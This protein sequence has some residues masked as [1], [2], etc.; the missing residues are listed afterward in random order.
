[1]IQIELSFH[2]HKR[3]KHI[4]LD[5]FVSCVFIIPKRRIATLDYDISNNGQWMVF[6]LYRYPMALLFVLNGQPIYVTCNICRKNVALLT[7]IHMESK[8]HI[9]YHRYIPWEMHNYKYVDWDTFTWIHSHCIWCYSMSTP[10]LPAKR[11][12][13]SPI[14]IIIN[15]LSRLGVVYCC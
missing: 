7:T 8:H 5:R 15:G 6:D 11:L 4:V 1:M 3:I 2:F 13:A 10:A 9:E 12:N 14:I